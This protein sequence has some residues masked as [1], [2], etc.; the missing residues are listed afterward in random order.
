MT[1]LGKVASIMN[2][3]EVII[4]KGSNDGVEEGMTFRVTEE[5]IPVTDPDTG[6]SLGV[7]IKDKIGVKISEVHPKFSVARTY[8]TYTVQEPSSTFRVSIGGGE[9]LLKEV[10]RVRTLKTAGSIPIENKAFSPI[11]DD[12]SI[13]QVGDL[14]I[15]NYPAS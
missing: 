13:V 10:T 6:E 15:Q 14:V 9:R 2:E 12:E 7:F 1:I 3:R 11:K 4:N 5:G 8:E